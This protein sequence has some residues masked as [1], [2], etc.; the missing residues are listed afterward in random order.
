MASNPPTRTLVLLPGMD[1]TGELFA[2]FI[3]TLSPAF[4]AVPLEFPRDQELTYPELADLVYSLLPESEPFVL[5][6]E[7][8]S[9]P[10]AVQV[11][12]RK[13]PNLK[14]LILCAGFASS[15]TYGWARRLMPLLGSPLCRVHLPSFIVRRL[16]VGQGAPGS[17][18]NAVKDAVASVRPEVLHS[19]LEMT[20]A[21]DAR[22]ELAQIGV[23]ILY[24]QAAGDRVVPPRC[25]D[26]IRR[27]KP[28]TRVS[29]VAG[30]HLLLQREPRVT[31]Q[32]IADFVERLDE[33]P[34]PR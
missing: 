12:A 27:I 9:S 30:P 16:L 11:A 10:I 15:P 8:F 34:H 14:A 18:V 20:A 3:S 19:R 25:L 32:I 21:C 23:P 33:A 31:A 6:A 22:T 7:S 2:P 4:K 1:G 17:L 24:L 13:S 5:V 26:E 29:M 28:E